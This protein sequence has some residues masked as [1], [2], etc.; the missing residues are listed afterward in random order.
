MIIPVDDIESVYANAD[1]VY[2]RIVSQVLTD[3]KVVAALCDR[4][5]NG[6]VFIPTDIVWNADQDVSISLIDSLIKVGCERF[7]DVWRKVLLKKLNP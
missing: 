6:D 1:L 7:G 3:K 4:P 2:K 5:E